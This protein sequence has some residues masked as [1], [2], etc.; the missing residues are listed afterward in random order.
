MEFPQVGEHC[1]EVTC[2]KLDFLP[3]K[4]DACGKIFCCEHMNYEKH[5]CPGAHKKD[6][7]V[8]VCP[9]CGLPVPTPRNQKPDVTVSAHIDNHCMAD[10]AKAKKKV[11]S[12]KCNVPG[13][14]IK[15]MIP[16][17][18]AQ[19]K[20][21]FCLLHRFPDVHSCQKQKNGPLKA[22]LA[23]QQESTSSHIKAVHGLLSEDEALARALSAS[24]NDVEGFF[25]QKEGNGRRTMNSIGPQRC[26]VS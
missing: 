13:C 12:N 22:A 16:V 3:I 24:M 7:Q 17:I 8:P 19:C 2:N 6:V 25:G 11:N 1:N 14:K 21:N 9:L 18:C 15:E 4:C 20:K 23:R 26:H 5:K 10:P